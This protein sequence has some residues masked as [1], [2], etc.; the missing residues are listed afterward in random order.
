MKGMLF[1]AGLVSVSLLLVGMLGSEQSER[2]IPDSK[3]GL[4]KTSVF[5]VPEPEVNLR[6]ESD[7]GDR[8]VIARSFPGQPPMIPHGND[9]F[10]PITLGENMCLD[11][12]AVEVKEEG[13]PTPIPGS[14]YV[15]LRA[16]PQSRQ[17][18]VVGAR[19]NCLSCH[20]S[21]GENALLVENIFSN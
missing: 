10:L 8:S 21:P 6:N 4:S 16:A 1:L 20:V 19:Y 12:H 15:D 14:H 3:L 9:D 7:P 18:G 5:G 13:E 2:G 17:D 11:C